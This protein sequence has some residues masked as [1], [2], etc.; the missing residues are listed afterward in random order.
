MFAKA[1][2]WACVSG[3]IQLSLLIGPVL[4]PVSLMAAPPKKPNVLFVA[5]DDLNHWVGY[6]GRNPQTI[7]PNIDRLAARGTRFTR[8]YAAAPMCN[9]SRAALMSG[10]RPNTTGVYEN[11]DDWRTVIAPE[12]CLTTTFRQAGYSVKGAGKIYHG[13]FPRRNEWDD[14]LERE[15]KEP[16]PTGDT[17]VGG[18]R[19]APLDCRDEDLREW[20]I[21]QYGIDELAIPHDRPFFLAIG[22]H[23]PHM[24]WNVPRKYYDMHPLDQI[25]L[26]PTQENDLSD[27]PPAGIK[28]ARP[29]GDHR[30]IVESGRWKDAIQGYLAAISYCDAMIGRLMAAYDTSP[31]RDNTIIVFWGDHGWHLGEKQHWRKFTLW[32][33]AT[34]TPLI[35]V[36][37]GITK[38]NTVCD[39]T[40]DL[41]SIYP[42]LT[43]LCG[44]ATPKHIEGRS[45]R[46]LLIDS[47][48]AWDVPAVTTYRFGNHAVRTEGWR[49][50]RYVN[51][52]E[53]L[54]DEKADPYEWTNLA[55]DHRFAT[56]KAELRSLLPT[57]NQPDINSGKSQLPD[58]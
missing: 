17:G 3:L 23:K 36:V 44:I 7:T 1:G 12:L 56:Q 51:G 32:E 46:S 41:M 33:E 27:I 11:E 42:T 10:L 40:V 50:I 58:K 37:P 26:P 43:D 22:L 6:L 25:Q 28:I 47:Q 24:P 57:K 53:E 29:A 55:L 13:S 15:R 35:W 8:S 34:R 14:Y 2:S 49:Y 21:V 16:Q 45:I 30:Q 52:D 5:V 31:D 20:G 9:P 38:A 18:I 4:C 48:S 54:Y 39:R 19:F